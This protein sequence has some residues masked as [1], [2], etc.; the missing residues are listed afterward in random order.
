MT[1]WN[2]FRKES[3]H[4]KKSL[5]SNDT[6]RKFHADID[7]WFGS[8]MQELSHLHLTSVKPEIVFHPKIDISESKKQYKITVEVP[9]VHPKDLHLDIENHVITVSGEKKSSHESSKEE[10]AR[11][12]ECSYGEFERVL[13]L[14]EDADMETMQA[15]FLHGSLYITINRLD[16]PS[17]KKK[18]EIKALS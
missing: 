16:L 12:M 10:Y 6:L 9:G 15:E 7:R 3:H 11:S 4:A 14:P 18:V 2:W 13:A 5:E 1:V 17:N 8:A